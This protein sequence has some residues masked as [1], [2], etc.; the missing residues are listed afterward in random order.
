MRKAKK[1]YMYKHQKEREGKRAG[2][3][4]EMPQ[5]SY[6]HCFLPPLATSLYIRDDERKSGDDIKQEKV[7]IINCFKFHARLSTL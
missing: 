4:D 7:K 3:D 6:F 1:F 2:A 5:F